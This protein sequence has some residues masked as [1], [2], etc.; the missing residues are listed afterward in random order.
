MSR[1]RR[2]AETGLAER[3]ATAVTYALM[4]AIVA[5]LLSVGFMILHGGVAANLR[6]G[7]DCLV[8][9]DSASG[10]PSGEVPPGGDPGPPPGKTTTTSSSTSTTSTTRPS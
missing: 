5:L 6:R 9:L 2:S 4:A 1:R 7:G 3:G 8:S 10:C